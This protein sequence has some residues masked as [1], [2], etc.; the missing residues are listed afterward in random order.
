[1]PSRRVRGG[2]NRRSCGVVAQMVERVLS[3]HEAEGSMPSDSSQILLALDQK[4]FCRALAPHPA[5]PS[6]RVRGGA[7][8]R[9]CGVVA[10]MVERVLSMHEAEG[11]MPSDSIFGR[12]SLHNSTQSFTCCRGFEQ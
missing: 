7:D 2:A 5:M 9:S 1:M 6:R 10:Q 4:A 11:S 8:R 3:M 12:L